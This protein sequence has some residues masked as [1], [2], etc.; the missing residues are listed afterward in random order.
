MLFLIGA[1]LGFAAYII[2]TFEVNNKVAQLVH[3]I[4]EIIHETIFIYT[5]VANNLNILWYLSAL[6]GI[7]LVICLIILRINEV[8][9]IPKEE[10]KE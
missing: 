4:L 3:L 8:Y 2:L 7:V 1:F 10:I 9:I 5:L 6:E